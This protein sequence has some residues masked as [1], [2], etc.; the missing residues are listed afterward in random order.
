MW[1]THELLAS[2]VLLVFTV[3]AR[4]TAVAGVTS[5]AIIGCL[6]LCTVNAT[7]RKDKIKFVK[8]VLSAVAMLLG[9]TFNLLKG[10]KLEIFVAEFFTQP[11]PA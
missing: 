5:V 6:A 9:T 7:R 10:P 11:K 1:K 8:Q 2:L 3:A 4:I